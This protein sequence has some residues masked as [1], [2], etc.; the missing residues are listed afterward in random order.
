MKFDGTLSLIREEPGPLIPEE[1][2]TLETAAAADER[3]TESNI[4]K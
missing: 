3:E 2:P 4:A 1:T